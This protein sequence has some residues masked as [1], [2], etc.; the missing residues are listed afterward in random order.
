MNPMPDPQKC[1]L[2]GTRQAN[3]AFVCAK[4]GYQFMTNVEYARLRRAQMLNQVN[5]QLNT[6]PTPQ[7]CPQCG[8]IQDTPARFCPQCGHQFAV[9]PP[10][11]FGGGI[12]PIYSSGGGDS[13]DTPPI[14]LIDTPLGA[15]I[16][17]GQGNQPPIDPRTLQMLHNQRIQAAY[18]KRQQLQRRAMVG[19]AIGL[20]VS[21]LGYATVF[22]LISGR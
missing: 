8:L 3:L 22:M 11:S 6:V 2:C 7:P 4:C 20:L 9:L 19:L 13:A 14:R 5:S 10:P 12:N 21:V 1:P 15:L 17:D 16:R 18:Q